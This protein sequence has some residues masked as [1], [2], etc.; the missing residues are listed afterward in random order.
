MYKRQN[1]KDGDV[2]KAEH[3]KKIE[4]GLLEAAPCMKVTVN[5]GVADKSAG[6]IYDH[7][8]ADGVVILQYNDAY[9]PLLCADN[10]IAWFGYCSDEGICT[11]L[12]I[13]ENDLEE[14]MFERVSK[15][16][17]ESV[18]GDI[19]AALDHIIE[20]QEELIGV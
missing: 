15:S 5:A 14:Y 11:V 20:I 13:C 2:L 17:F 1:F 8:A 19:E 18:V 3:L 7:V 4:D 6:D 12:C 9:Y 10:G 16:E